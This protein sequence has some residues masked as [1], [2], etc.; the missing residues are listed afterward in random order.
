MATVRIIGPGRAGSALALALAA[1]GWEVEAPYRRGDELATAAIGV[2][3]C[4]IA[5]PDAAVAEVAAQLTPAPGTVVAHLAGSLGL[6]V[7]EPHPHRASL[8]PLVSI[9]RPDVGA[10]R[11]R[12]GA[13]FAVAANAPGAERLVNQVV[14]DL[15]GRAIEVPDEARATYHAAACIASNHLVALL[16]QVERV[17]AGAGVPLE[18]YLDL[19][20]GTVDNVE[21]MGT[22]GALTG[23]VARGDE[24]TIQRHLA[25][26]DPSERA[27]YAAMVAEARRLVDPSARLPWA[28]GRSGR[29]T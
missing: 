26:I 29:E 13:W 20:R 22:S 19:V 9:P 23:P 17:A 24:G 8:H 2:D 6:D 11:L 3:L 16:A 5:T 27:G 1:T 18:A 14:I 4:V 7:L 15:G 10:Q 12:S 21:A 25:A 28:N